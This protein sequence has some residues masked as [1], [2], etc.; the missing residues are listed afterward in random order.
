MRSV[1]G[2]NSFSPCILSLTE[3]QFYD[4]IVSMMQEHSQEALQNKGCSRVDLG[5]ERG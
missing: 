2:I 3:S 1:T 4:L 5:G